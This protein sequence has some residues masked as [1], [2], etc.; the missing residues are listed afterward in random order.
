MLVAQFHG[1][2][3]VTCDLLR[4]L[5]G[6]V[7]HAVPHNET[8]K[9]FRAAFELS[10][11]FQISLNTNPRFVLLPGIGTGGAGRFP[12]RISLPMAASLFP[13]VPPSLKPIHPR[14]LRDPPYP[15]SL[16]SGPMNR[17]RALQRSFLGVGLIVQDVE[18]HG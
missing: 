15:W 7:S 16:R 14:N 12:Q 6:S 13:G 18:D 5:Q 3:M 2:R 11:P 8:L 17:V 9:K 1:M 4:R 10:K